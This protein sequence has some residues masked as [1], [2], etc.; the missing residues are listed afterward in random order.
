MLNVMKTVRFLLCAMVQWTWG[1][2]QNAI[3]LLLFLVFLPNRHF[4]FRSS[5]VTCWKIPYSAGCGMF[6]FLNDTDLSESGKGAISKMDYDLLVHE[7]GHCLQSI[8]LGPLF[9]P[10]IAIPSIIWAALPCFERFRK[11]KGMSYYE[12]YCE[13]WANRFGDRMCGNR[14]VFCR[15]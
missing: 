5:V 3:G 4:V 12:L 2:V 13:K 10:V 8:L 15:K 14:R 9:L 7:Y 6:I 1:I 11:R